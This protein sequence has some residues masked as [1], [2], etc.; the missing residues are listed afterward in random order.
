MDGRAEVER[1]RW[2]LFLGA[3]FCLAGAVAVEI[4]AGVVWPSGIARPDGGYAGRAPGQAVWG[5]AALDLILV[6][7]MAVLVAGMLVPRA[8]ARVQ[9]LLGFLVFLLG[10]LAVLAATLAV[11]AGLVAMVTLLMAVP[12]GTAIYFAV[13]VPFPRGAVSA[14]LA[15]AMAFKLAFAVCLVLAQP[16]FLQMRSL[17]LLIA[18]SLV[19]TWLT[20]VI[21]A[22]VP[23]FLGAIGDAVAA[24]IAG[25]LALVWAVFLML[26]SLPG[27]VRA[28][29]SLV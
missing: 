12:F 13:H 22:F 19:A 9:A 26:A 7:T 16:R 28:V 15:A 4:G 25:I 2:P 20:G 8:V 3:L 23:G 5:L 21:L 11:F 14:A 10:A 17:V 6:Y 1:L 24:L 29:R 27:V 18:T